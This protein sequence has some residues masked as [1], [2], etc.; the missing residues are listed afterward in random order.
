MIEKKYI[1][2]IDNDYT[3]KL[4]PSLLE[5]LDVEPGMYATII[6]EGDMLVVKF[7]AKRTSYK[8]EKDITVEEMEKDIEEALD[9]MVSL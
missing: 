8:L 1:V 4:P 7:K 9:E 3:I 6:R 5:G 2:K